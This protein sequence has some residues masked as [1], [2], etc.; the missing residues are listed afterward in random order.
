M[1]RALPK[2]ELDEM[3]WTYRS[4]FK[5]SAIASSLVGLDPFV[6]FIQFLRTHD[7]TFDPQR[8]ERAL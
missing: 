4:S 1:T 2:F 3:P 5:Q 7:V 6:L 8:S